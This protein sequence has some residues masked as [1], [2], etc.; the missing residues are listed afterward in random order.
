[1]RALIESVKVKYRTNFIA[2]RIWSLFK[3][4]RYLRLVNV[5]EHA[6]FAQMLKLHSVDLLIDIGANVGQ[7][8][9]DVR[10]AGYR[11]DILSIEPSTDVFSRLEMIT[12][13]DDRWS[14]IQG[15]ASDETGVEMLYV[16]D[17][18]SLSSSLNRPSLVF[19]KIFPQIGI[20]KTESVNTFRID[21]H[22]I[23]ES[24]N[25]SFV[26]LAIKLDIQGHELRALK[27]SV[28]IL[29]NTILIYCEIS[30]AEI[31][32]DQTNIAELIAFLAAHK[33]RLVDFLNQQYREGRLIQADLVFQK[34]KEMQ[35]GKSN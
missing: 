12:K 18:S 31:Y 33:F 29:D 9:L 20:S 19:S 22:L 8:G 10:A 1:M 32:V 16:A 14:I 25:N 21:S 7:F 24:T 30:F 15:A 3:S 17:N 23:L 4:L 26:T 6:K 28:K 11:G 2:R 34:D 27:G 5:N 35:D 13:E